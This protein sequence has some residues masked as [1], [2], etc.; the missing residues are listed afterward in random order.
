M[1]STVTKIKAVSELSDLHQSNASEFSAV[2]DYIPFKA[3]P[4]SKFSK[5]YFD[6]I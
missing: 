5:Y 2:M 6:V 3:W 1:K 4:L